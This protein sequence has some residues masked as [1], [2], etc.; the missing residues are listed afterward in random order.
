MNPPNNRRMSQQDGA[1]T[2][3]NP[4]P[5]QNRPAPARAG[6]PTVA[7]RASNPPTKANA[8]ERATAIVRT[9]RRRQR[10]ALFAILAVT[11]VVGGLGTYIYYAFL[12]PVIDSTVKIIDISQTPVSERI[13]P[14]GTPSPVATPPPT[15]DEPINILLLGLDERPGDLETRADTQ[16]VVHV[17]PINKRAV[18]FSIPRDMWVKIPGFGEGRINTSYQ[19][20]QIKENNIKG[21]GPTLA[22]SAIEQNFGIRIHHY[23]QVN[24]TGFEEVIDALGGVTL[25]VPRPLVD[26]EYPL[27]NYGTTRLYI[28][29]GIQHMNGKV[30]LQYAR[31]RHADSDLGRNYRQQ[32]VLLALRQQGLTL[33]I[34]SKLPKLSE[35][36]SDAVDTDIN[37]PGKLVSL[38][39]LAQDI[40]PESIETF[41]IEPPMVYEYTIPGSGAQVLMPDW[42][43]IKPKVAELFADPN[44]AREKARVLVLNGTTTNGLAGNARDKLVLEGV[45]VSAIASAPN[46]GSHLATTV[47]DYTGGAKPR[48]LEA[49]L[50]H[51]GLPDSAV[52]DGGDDPEWVI[53]ANG[54]PLRVTQG[55]PTGSEPVDIVVTIGSDRA[56]STRGTPTPLP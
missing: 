25:D 41:I 47:T 45:P 28:P 26:N 3:P 20:G 31:S 7:L 8:A 15:L 43:L 14:D 4:Q 1:A 5:N 27:P 40:G 56:A 29:A 9:Q 33:D 42:N 39:Q 38:A 50:K 36:L 10:I 12:K 53:A 11:L 16:I 37:P 34:L 6:K 19:F 54:N 55:V 22:M 48:T 49:V 24:F 2:R 18:M 35:Q 52:E 51:L 21:G 13:G 17:D 46:Q 30:A 32:Q 23:A 44:I